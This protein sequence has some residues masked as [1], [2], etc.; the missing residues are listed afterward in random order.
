[1]T[2]SGYRVTG[3]ALTLDGLFIGQAASDN[4]FQL[5]VRFQRDALLELFVDGEIRFEDPV[6]VGFDASGPLFIRSQGLAE[7][8][9]SIQARVA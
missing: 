6:Q 8:A 4:R 2:G 5:P 9:E 7:F 3:N 1:M